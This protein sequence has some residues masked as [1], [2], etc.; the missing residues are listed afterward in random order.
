MG[1]YYFWIYFWLLQF[2]YYYLIFCSYLVAEIVPSA[3][4]ELLHSIHFIK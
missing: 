3:T 1:F 2:I 4:C